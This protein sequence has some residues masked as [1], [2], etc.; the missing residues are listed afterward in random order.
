M[1]LTFHGVPP[2]EALSPAMEIVDFVENL[3]LWHMYRYLEQNHIQ[4]LLLHGMLAD[5]P[6]KISAHCKY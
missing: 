5:S 3:K 1:L 4:I 2:I 6:T